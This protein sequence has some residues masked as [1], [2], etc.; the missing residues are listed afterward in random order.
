MNNMQE[1]LI[2]K[3]C[4]PCEAGTKPLGEPQ[5]SHYLNDLEDW[6]LANEETLLFREYIM[7]N[8][9]DAIAF[10]EQIAG[11]AEEENHHPDFHLTGY[12][13]LRIELSTHAIGGLSENDFIM[14]AKINAVPEEGRSAIME[15][16]KTGKGRGNRTIPKSW[17][18]FKESV[19]K[20]TEK[21]KDEKGSL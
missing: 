17:D 18:K 20:N 5:I 13:K 2:Q 11:I 12:K 8:F 14:A 10:M 15:R 16:I 1:S 7:K 19:E 21:L 6:A 9:L 4:R 3:K